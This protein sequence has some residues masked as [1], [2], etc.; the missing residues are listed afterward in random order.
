MLSWLHLSA[1][2]T[3]T[4]IETK[5]LANFHPDQLKAYMFNQSE[6]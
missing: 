6:K 3:A 4:A 1:I 2:S 5:L